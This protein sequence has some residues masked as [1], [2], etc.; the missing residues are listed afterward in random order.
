MKCGVIK[1]T[2][3]TAFAVSFLCE[4]ERII[5][6]TTQPVLN[7][8]RE[9]NPT[10]FGFEDAFYKTWRQQIKDMFDFIVD[11]VDMVD[12]ETLY[13]SCADFESYVFRLLDL[14]PEW[15]ISERLISFLRRQL[16]LAFAM[17]HCFLSDDLMQNRMNQCD[18]NLQK[19][20]AYNMAMI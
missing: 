5:R 18:M 7:D 14:L 8:M 16:R 15:I 10:Q 17:H 12:G 13:I 3:D 9:R 6:E 19:P 11:N 20:L 2:C 4:V 1:M